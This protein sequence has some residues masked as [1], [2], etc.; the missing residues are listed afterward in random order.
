MKRASKKD[1]PQSVDAKAFQVALAALDYLACWDEGITVTSAFDFPWTATTARQ[2]LQ[3]I[4]GGDGRPAA[5]E[6]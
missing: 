3:K 5:E 1:A 6:T 4:R 2:A